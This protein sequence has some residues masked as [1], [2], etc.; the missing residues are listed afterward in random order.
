MSVANVAGFG[1]PAGA[2][3]VYIQNRPQF[4]VPG[5]EDAIVGINGDIIQQINTSCGNGWRK[6]FNV[7]AKWVFDLHRQLPAKQTLLARPCCETWQQYRDRELL[8][9]SGD[10]ALLFSPVATR[11]PVNVVMGRTYARHSG[12]ADAAQ[13]VRHDFGLLDA[14]RIIITPYFDYRQL[15]NEKIAFLSSLLTPR[16]QRWGKHNV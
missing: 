8:T 12:L 13:W 1:N 4:F 6:V 10:T 3:H 15:T 16:W 5:A 2:I 9:C 14:Q 11:A 7:Y